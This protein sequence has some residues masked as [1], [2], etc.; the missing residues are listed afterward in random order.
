M[1]NN[2]VHRFRRRI[3][4]LIEDCD[5]MIAD[6]EW[7]AENRPE[8]PPLDVEDIRVTRHGAVKALAALNNGERIEP[9]W[10]VPPN[11]GAT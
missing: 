5:G 10:I 11:E 4:N 9:S 6:A 7:W 8:H 2:F 1:I 3:K